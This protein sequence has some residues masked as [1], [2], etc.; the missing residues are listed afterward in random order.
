MRR[1]GAA[2]EAGADARAR[3]TG[4]AREHRSARHPVADRRLTLAITTP[5]VNVKDVT[6]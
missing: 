3:P 4:S 6:I 1:C 2:A 5:F